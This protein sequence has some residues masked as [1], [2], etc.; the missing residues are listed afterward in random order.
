MCDLE[1]TVKIDLYFGAFLVEPEHPLGAQTEKNW[2]IK[3]VS[4]QFPAQTNGVHAETAPANAAA[5]L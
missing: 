4:N 2:T 5:V 3:A 1:D